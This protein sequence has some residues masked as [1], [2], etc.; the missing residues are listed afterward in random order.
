MLD[1]TEQLAKSTDDT[2]FFVI[3][4]ADY[5]ML[6]HELVRNGLDDVLSHV[7]L[8]PL[9]IERECGDRP[10]DHIVEP[11]VVVIAAPDG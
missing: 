11:I 1:I 9:A 3:S 4:T 6:A 2:E 7:R 5:E 8:W 10:L